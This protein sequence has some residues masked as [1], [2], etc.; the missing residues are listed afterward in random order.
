MSEKIDD[1]IRSAFE[2]DFEDKTIECLP[3]SQEMV[4]ATRELL[5]QLPPD[6]HF[7][8]IDVNPYGLIRLSWI[9]K[10]VLVVRSSTPYNWSLVTIDKVQ[11]FHLPSDID[12]LVQS[13]RT[14]ML[15]I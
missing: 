12:K 2:T 4:N 13:I 3:L 15:K 8:D 10:P 1:L 9:I 11:S 6:L 14:S 5:R 7:P